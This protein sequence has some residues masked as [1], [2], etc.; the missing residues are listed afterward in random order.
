M[1]GR[2]ACESSFPYTSTPWVSTARAEMLSAKLYT[3]WMEREKKTWWSDSLKKERKCRWQGSVYESLHVLFFHSFSIISFTF[4][5][6]QPTELIRLWYHFTL[7]SHYYNGLMPSSWFF[8]IFHVFVSWL[9]KHMCE[10]CLIA[11]WIVSSLWMWLLQDKAQPMCWS[12]A[13]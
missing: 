5:W 10:E 13:A 4:E 2:R 3:R 1:A 6:N 8:C 11:L 7:I 12:V 9:Q